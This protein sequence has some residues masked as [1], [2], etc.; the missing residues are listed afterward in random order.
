MNL[1]K[2]FEMQKVLDERIETEHPRKRHES[3]FN[4]RVI[5]FIVEMSELLNEKRTLFKFWSRKKDNN[6]KALI[7]FVDGIHF[8][9]SIG[10]EM[11][12]TPDYLEPRILDYENIEAQVLE[13]IHAA[14]GMFEV[15]YEQYERVFELYLGFGSML[16]FTPEQIEQAYYQKNE[17]NHARQAQGY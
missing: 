16:G 12:I 9:L 4:K 13:T 10:L 14:S 1:S 17:I 5:A 2:L 15:D 3:R 7:E 6:E 11:G 8:L